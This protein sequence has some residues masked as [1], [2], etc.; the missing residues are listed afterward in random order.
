MEDSEKNDVQ[1]LETPLEEKRGVAEVKVIKGDE[2]FNEAL[3]KDPPRPFAPRTLFLYLACLLGEYCHAKGVRQPS[4]N[5]ASGFFCSTVNGYDGS[6]LNNLFINPTFEKFFHGSNAGIWAGI[7]TSMYQIGSI[8]CLP[9]I[10]PIIDNFGR[11]GGMWLGALFVVVGTI[12]QGVTVHVTNY[13][14]ATSQ[15]VD[16]PRPSITTFVL[17]SSAGLWAAGSCS[18]LVSV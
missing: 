9:F 18:V 1:Y 14:H 10:G 4:A 15:Y 3:L 16:C 17:T 13:H 12:V 6:L 8:V 11:R 2:A 5:T 7:V